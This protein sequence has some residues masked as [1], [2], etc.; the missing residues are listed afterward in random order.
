M[1]SHD[2]SMI[3]CIPTSVDNDVIM[4]SPVDSIVSYMV[5]ILEIGTSDRMAITVFPAVMHLKHAN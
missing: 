3:T 5:S 4:M 1:I 2:I